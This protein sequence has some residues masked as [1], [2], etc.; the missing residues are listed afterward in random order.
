MEQKELYLCDPDKN[1][2]CEKTSCKDLCMMTTHK[3]YA[4]TFE[5]G[6]PIVA[7]PIDY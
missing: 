3:E 1:V 5:N 4:A 7:I 6:K 2:E